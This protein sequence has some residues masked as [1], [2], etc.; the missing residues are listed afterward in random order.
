MELP[1]GEWITG[2]SVRPGGEAGPG[3]LEWPV[4][5]PG[6]SGDRVPAVGLV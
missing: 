3:L 6:G 4:T 5:A 1:C 2:A